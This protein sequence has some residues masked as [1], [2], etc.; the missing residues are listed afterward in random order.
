MR[1]TTTDTTLVL[2]DAR[3]RVRVAGTLAGLYA[4][5]VALGT[6]S[7]PGYRHASGIVDLGHYLVPS[8]REAVGERTAEWVWWLGTLPLELFFVAIVGVVLLT[9]TSAR[10]A[11]CL[12]AMYAL[13]WLFLLATTLPPPDQIVWR[14]PAGIVTLGNPT[15]H[16][17][18]FSGHVANAFV[19]AL[20]TRGARRWVRAI[21]WGGVAFETLLVL[22]TR[23]HY[24]IDVIGALFIGYTTHRVSLDLLAPE[25]AA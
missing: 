15:D 14:F 17:L 11:L 5:A 8:L 4:V 12:Y 20:A 6:L 23:T 7:A 9:G 10:L 2:S 22:S 18:W 16:D 1:A 19:I 24:S 3:G 21:A 13:H 25:P